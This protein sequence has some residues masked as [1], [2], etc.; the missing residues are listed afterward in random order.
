MSLLL[1]FARPEAVQYR[2]ERIKLVAGHTYKLSIKVRST[3]APQTIIIYLTNSAYTLQAATYPTILTADTWQM[4]TLE[5]TATLSDNNSILWIKPNATSQSFYLDKANLIDLTVER[6][7]YRIMRIV[8]SMMP[9]TFI[10][11]LTLREKTATE[12]AS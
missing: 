7:Q 5:F 2:H 4:I 9:G 12:T 3:V 10:Q 1:F 11:T 8:G 6:K